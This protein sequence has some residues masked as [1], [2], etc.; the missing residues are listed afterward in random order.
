MKKCLTRLAFPDA[1]RPVLSFSMPVGF[2][3]RSLQPLLDRLGTGL[4]RRP[5]VDPE[6]RAEG[7]DW[8]A[9]AET[10][11]GMK[12]LDMLHDAA[13]TIFEENVPGDFLEAGTWRGGAAIFLRALLAAYGDEARAVWVADSFEG[14]P[15]PDGRYAEDEGDSH[16]R[17]KAVLGVS[18]EEV[19]GNFARYDLLDERVRFLPGWFKDTLPVAPIER[20]S[21]LRI[22]GDMY[23]STRDALESLYGKLSVGGYAVID[24][25]GALPECR[26]AVDDFRRGR[27]IEEP[28]LPIDWTGAYWRRRA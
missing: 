4:Y 1:Y 14:L 10:M 2:L 15:R 3:E 6:R 17:M 22:D 12:R 19:R 13:R 25:Y 20:L 24:D 7:R 26:K 11:I 9:E 5:G 28:I 21:L 27:S 8:P 23:S 18:L 16:W